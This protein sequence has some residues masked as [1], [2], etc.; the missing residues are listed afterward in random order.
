MSTVL[1][2]WTFAQLPL[3]LTRYCRINSK[4][5][6]VSGAGNVSEPRL[7]SPVGRVREIVRAQV[8]VFQRS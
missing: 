6:Q 1:K 8:S 4:K 3:L 7:M 2:N 5:S